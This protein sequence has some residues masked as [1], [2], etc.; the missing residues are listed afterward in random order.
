ELQNER[1]N[2]VGTTLPVGT[3]V[4][5]SYHALGQQPN[6]AWVFEQIYDTN[7]DP[8]ADV[9]VDRNNDGILNNDDRYYVQMVPNFFYGFGTSLIKGNWDFTANFRGQSGGHVYDGH[10]VA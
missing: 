4:N 10:K 3:G 2:V 6:S 9:F 1:I 8:L 5:V 7:G